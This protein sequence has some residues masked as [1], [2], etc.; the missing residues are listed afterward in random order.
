MKLPADRF[1]ARTARGGGAR[2]IRL[3]VGI[4]D[5]G[6]ARC[7]QLFFGM[8]E[9]RGPGETSRPQR[10]GSAAPEIRAPRRAISG[11]IILERPRDRLRWEGVN[12]SAFPVFSAA[13]W[14]AAG[15]PSPGARF[16]RPAGPR[17]PRGWCGAPET[18]GATRRS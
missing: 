10:T 13:P 2:T 14:Q 12:L 7:V 1:S 9:A 3:R 15:T 5:N 8:N 4:Y 6:S 16:L 11:K 18:T 17:A